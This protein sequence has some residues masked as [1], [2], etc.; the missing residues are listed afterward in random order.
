MSKIEEKRQK[1]MKNIESWLRPNTN[2]EVY[3]I[4]NNKD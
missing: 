3:L 2:I 1:S 4:R